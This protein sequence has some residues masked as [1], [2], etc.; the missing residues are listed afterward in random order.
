MYVIKPI[1]D[2]IN[3][4]ITNEVTILPNS[5][6]KFTLMHSIFVAMVNNVRRSNPRPNVHKNPSC[7]LEEASACS[8]ETSV[9]VPSEI[10][11]DRDLEIRTNIDKMVIVA[12]VTTVAISI[13]ITFFEVASVWPLNLP[14][15][16]T[17]IETTQESS[18]IAEI[19][20]LYPFPDVHVLRLPVENGIQKTTFKIFLKR[21]TAVAVMS[22]IMYTYQSRTCYRMVLD[23]HALTKSK[24]Y[25]REKLLFLSR[26]T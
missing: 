16:T 19:F 23:L 12:I 9:F 7:S 17:T 24:H 22:A 10:H 3:T 8:D 18:T 14:T 25:K 4:N 6:E 11:R 13:H 15:I 26:Q 1:C 5:D 20:A 2:T 21:V